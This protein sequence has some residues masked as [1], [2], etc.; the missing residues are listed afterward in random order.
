VLCCD[1]N[2]L[3]ILS[4]F[5]PTSLEAHTGS[6]VGLWSND[7]IAYLNPAWYQFSYEN[8]GEPGLSARWDLGAK[9]TLAISPQLL[10]FYVRAISACRRRQTPWEHSYECSSADAFRQFRMKMYPLTPSGEVLIVHSLALERPHRWE[11]DVC[12]PLASDYRDPQ[13]LIHQCAHCRRFLNPNAQHCW[14]WISDW[15]RE[16]PS[17]V[18]DA[19]CPVCRDYYYPG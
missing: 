11:R 10:P 18:A 2:F 13:G 8:G 4:P 5:D 19:L 14:D 16:P 15:V 7:T 12:A 3:P 1:S 17:Q 9:M 6:I